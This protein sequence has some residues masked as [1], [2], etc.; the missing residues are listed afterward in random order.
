MSHQDS[1][2]L[3]R[4]TPVPGKPGGQPG[5]SAR[6]PGGQPRHRPG[7][8]AAQ[9]PTS[10]KCPAPTPTRPTGRLQYQVT[11]GQPRR[12]GLLGAR[13]HA[14]LDVTPRHPPAQPADSRSR[15]TRWPARH[16]RPGYTGTD[17]GPMSHGDTHQPDQQLQCQVTAWP[18]APM[19]MP[20]E[21]SD[22]DPLFN[23]PD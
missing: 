16:R 1:H 2:Q 12:L 7:G 8:N 14:G 4:Q 18:G 17:I 22:H 13:R 9:V 23:H 11:G 6:R 19:A 15:Q 21:R 3:N 5:P 20:G 10:G